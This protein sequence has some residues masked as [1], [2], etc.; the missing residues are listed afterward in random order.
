MLFD[1]FDYKHK[2]ANHAAVNP[3]I[4]Q[5]WQNFLQGNFTYPPFGTYRVTLGYRLPG[6]NTFTSQFPVNIIYGT[7]N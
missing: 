3:N 5:A 7:S 1:D 4:P 6:S 2:V